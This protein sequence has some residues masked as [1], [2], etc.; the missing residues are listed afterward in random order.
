MD[1]VIKW[2][3][4]ISNIV[5]ILASAIAIFL[6]VTKRESIATVFNLL[7]NYTY[8]LSLSE[9]KEKL[10]KL[11]DYNAKEPAEN[12]KIV[13]ILNEISGQIKGNDKLKDHF[14]KQLE[15]ISVFALGKKALSEP[16]KRA[17][18]SELRE[19]LR[20]LNVKNIDDL[21]GVSK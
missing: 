18:V 14:Q 2:V 21:V 19:R 1:E 4:L 12:E 3:T 8:Q 20:H 11:N 15:E 7:I 17:L 13:N 5:T 10:E 6:F 16:K 9:I